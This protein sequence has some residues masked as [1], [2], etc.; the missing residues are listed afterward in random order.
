MLTWSLHSLT[1]SWKKITCVKCELELNPHPFVFSVDFTAHPRK[2]TI[3]F[4]YSEHI[5]LQRVQKI[6]T[7]TKKAFC[8]L[9][10]I[11]I[12]KMESIY[13]IAVPFIK[14]ISNMLFLK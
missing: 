8:F 1:F 5:L 10:P 7:E 11:N 14:K 4:S 12:S 2:I 13:V 9:D 3:P 6:I